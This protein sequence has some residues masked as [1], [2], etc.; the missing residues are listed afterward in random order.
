MARG[1]KHEEKRGRRSSSKPAASELMK[2]IRSHSATSRLKNE[3]VSL[4]DSEKAELIAQ[5]KQSFPNKETIA[6]LAGILGMNKR[7]LQYFERAPQ[8]M[9]DD[10]VNPATHASLEEVFNRVPVDG[11]EMRESREPIHSRPRTDECLNTT[12]KSEESHTCFNETGDRVNGETIPV[13]TPAIRTVSDSTLHSMPLTTTSQGKSMQK[14]AEAAPIPPS[15]DTQQTNARTIPADFPKNLEMQ[16]PIPAV[17]SM[18]PFDHAE[19]EKIRS[20]DNDLRQKLNYLEI[21]GAALGIFAQLRSE[22]RLERT[23]ASEAKLESVVR[24]C[25]IALEAV[26]TSEDYY[27]KQYCENLI[28]D[29]RHW[30]QASAELKIK[31]RTARERLQWPVHPAQA[32]MRPDTTKPSGPSGEEICNLIIREFADSL[33]PQRKELQA[34]VVTKGA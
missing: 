25:D 29:I 14:I 28:G 8:K 11:N 22:L 19:W 4:R 1:K 17:T 12:S 16:L 24:S 26:T 23:K 30:N 27:L 34:K 20:M 33:V 7:D 32:R 15:V 9:V 18:R 13:P 5:V 31:A 6:T 10:S 2:R 3:W 21:W